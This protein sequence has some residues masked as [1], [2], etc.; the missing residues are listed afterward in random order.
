LPFY[1]ETSSPTLSNSPKC[2]SPV[3]I[4]VG[5]LRKSRSSPTLTTQLDRNQPLPTTHLH[6]PH[7]GYFLIHGRN[8]HRLP[9]VSILKKCR[10]TTCS[11]RR[12]KLRFND[13][14]TVVNPL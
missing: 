8:I 9:P 3:T 5:S 11:N 2:T 1:R 7:V 13:H 12:R 14:V 4:N 6:N 10:S